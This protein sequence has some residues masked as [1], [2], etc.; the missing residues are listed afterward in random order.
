MKIEYLNEEYSQRFN[1]RLHMSEGR[2]NVLEDKPIENTELKLQR[3]VR[4]KDKKNER[5]GEERK[6][7]GKE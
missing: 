1:C 7:E 3:E 4:M 5:T 6:E 2:I